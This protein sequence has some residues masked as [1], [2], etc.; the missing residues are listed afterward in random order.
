LN[1][2]P[3]A[4]EAFCQLFESENAGRLVLRRHVDHQLVEEQEWD[5]QSAGNNVAN[6]PGK[7]TWSGWR[8]L[9]GISDTVIDYALNEPYKADSFFDDGLLATSCKD[10]NSQG[11]GIYT[12][13]D[14]ST[15]SMALRHPSRRPC[16][17]C[18]AVKPLD[19]TKGEQQQQQLIS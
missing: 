12:G 2:H 10:P 5:H 18:W 8:S 3:D 16:A 19:T 13:A 11:N 7:F 17:D 15:S 9:R 1:A 4:N 14:W 6:N